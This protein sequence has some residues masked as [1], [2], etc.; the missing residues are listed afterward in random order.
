MKCLQQPHFFPLINRHTNL[1]QLSLIVLYASNG[2]CNYWFP[3]MRETFHWCMFTTMY[4]LRPVWNMRKIKC[5]SVHVRLLAVLLETRF[6]VIFVFCVLARLLTD[7]CLGQC[8]SWKMLKI[9]C[10]PAHINQLGQNRIC[11]DKADLSSVV[12]DPG[13]NAAFVMVIFLQNIK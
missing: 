6:C 7:T 2:E 8:T 3:C 5:F 11:V 4:H 10:F 1:E 13:E 9:K 12:T